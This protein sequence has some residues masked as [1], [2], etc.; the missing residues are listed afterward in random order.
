LLWKLFF[1]SYIQISLVFSI[2]LFIFKAFHHST[3]PALE[4]IQT[5]CV[6]NT[7]CSFTPLPGNAGTSEK[8]FLDLFGNFF[9]E[10]EIVIAMI[11]HRIITFYLNI[12]VGAMVYFFSRKH[13]QIKK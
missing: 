2:P 6:A 11:I 12:V 1:Y 8:I 5:E 10:N 13:T 7:V 3:Y 4:I 9:F